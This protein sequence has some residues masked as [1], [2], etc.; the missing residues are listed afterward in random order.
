MTQFVNDHITLPDT[1][2]DLLIKFLDQNGGKL[3]NKKRGKQFE[4]L[5]AKEI[6]IIENAFQDI[7]MNN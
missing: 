6:K 2:V 4:E 7:F 3:S 5:G 1:K